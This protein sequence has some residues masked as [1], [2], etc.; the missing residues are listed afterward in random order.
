MRD[1]RFAG[2]TDHV[3]NDYLETLVE[4]G[5]L[6]LSAL[7][8][9][10]V[11]LTVVAVRMRRRMSPV[12]AGAIAAVAAGA[13]CALVDFPLARPTELAWWWVAIIVALGATPAASSGMRPDASRLPDA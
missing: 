11:V 7:V 2:L 5:L 9:P 4:R 8:A 13:A 12:Q 6:G 1:R 10:L 3:H